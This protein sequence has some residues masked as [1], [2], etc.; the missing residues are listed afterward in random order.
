MTTP[1]PT[2]LHTVLGT[3]LTPSEAEDWEAEFKETMGSNPPT[4]DELIEVIRWRSG[5]DFKSR[6]RYRINFSELRM[7]TFMKRKRDRRASSLYP[8]SPECGLCSGSGWII[9]APKESTPL[10]LQSTPCLCN[11]G[12]TIME[13]CYRSEDETLLISNAN[14]ARTQHTEREAGIKEWAVKWIEAGRPSLAA[15]I[16]GDNR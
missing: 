16:E 10:Y 13:K 2:K 14:V 4:N 8:E 1:W 3:K 11:M 12:R 9:Y 6:P 15:T 5:P 7:W